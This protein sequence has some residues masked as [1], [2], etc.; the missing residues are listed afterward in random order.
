MY[1]GTCEGAAYQEFGFQ[2]AAV[3]VALG[4]YHNCAPNDKIRAEYVSEA[5]AESM[6]QLLVAAAKQMPNFAS[7]T[8]KLP[9]RLNQLLN[10]ARRNLSRGA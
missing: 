5:D 10:E 9:R 7:L 8:G 1:G 2:T 3:C 4:N 6:A